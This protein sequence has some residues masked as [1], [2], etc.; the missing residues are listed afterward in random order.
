MLKDEKAA[1]GIVVQRGLAS[2]PRRASAQS[3]DRRAGA[4]GPLD[5]HHEPDHIN[6]PDCRD[7]RR[8][9]DAGEPPPFFA[10]R[11][12]QQYDAAPS[13]EA[14]GKRQQNFRKPFVCGH[15]SPAIE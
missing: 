5:R 12:G 11:A 14:K 13:A 15:G 1:E 7:R 4:V 9:R 8:Q 10:G 3:R 6:R 2:Q